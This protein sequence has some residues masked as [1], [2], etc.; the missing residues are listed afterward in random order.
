LSQNL[1][2]IP[3]VTTSSSALSSRPIGSSVIY[4]AKTGEDMDTG[5]APDVRFP[6]DYYGAETDAYY[7]DAN[8]YTSSEEYGSVTDDYESDDTVKTGLSYHDQFTV[9]INGFV[10]NMIWLQQQPSVVPTSSS[11]RESYYLDGGLPLPCPCQVNETVD[12][13]DIEEFGVGT[14]DEDLE[15]ANAEL[16]GQEK[17]L[18]IRQD[19]PQE[20]QAISLERHLH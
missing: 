17:E 9:V 14:E 8:S 12:F 11:D 19:R 7:D 6:S 1:K 13:I 5:V 10:S 4:I 2:D 20:G 3:A 18:S 16:D 15:D